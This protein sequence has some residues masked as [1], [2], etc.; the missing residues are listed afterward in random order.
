MATLTKEYINNLLQQSPN[1]VAFNKFECIST[2]TYTDTSDRPYV[3]FKI[4]DDYPDLYFDVHDTTDYINQYYYRDS[5][6][7]WRLNAYLNPC[8]SA[9]AT[10][11]AST[12]Q[13][14]AFLRT[15]VYNWLSIADGGKCGDPNQGVMSVVKYQGFGAFAPP[16]IPTAVIVNNV[17]NT[18]ETHTQNGNAVTITITTQSEYL[19]FATPPNAV[20]TDTDGIQQ[21]TAA[22]V[23][24]VSG[25]VA[26]AWNLSNVDTAV[27]IVLN[28][29]IDRRLWTN[30]L[31]TQ[32][33]V[34]GVNLSNYNYVSYVN[35]ITVNVNSGYHFETSPKLEVYSDSTKLT[36]L[37][38]TVNVN[39]AS[40]TVDLSQY[41]TATQITILGEAVQN[42]F[43]FI[44]NI[45]NST[46]QTSVS[47]NT[48]TATITASASYLKFSTAPTVVYYVN[49]TL[50]TDNMTVATVNDRETA[51]AT[52]TADFDTVQFNGVLTQYFEV[53]YNLTNAT[54]IS[55]KTFVFVT[56]NT[57]QIEVAANNSYCFEVEPTALI[58]GALIYDTLPFTFVGGEEPF[59]CAVITIDLTQYDRNNIQVIEV[60][61]AA[62]PLVA[63]NYGAVNVYKVT[64]A[65]LNAFARLRYDSVHGLVD[66][67][68]YVITLKR[69]Y[70]RIAA[71]V[72]DT[73]KCANYDT[74]INC[75]VPITDTKTI[76]CGTLT[77]PQYA[78]NASDY[79]NTEIT[80][81]MPFVGFYTIPSDYINK[82]ISLVYVV[83][84]VTGKG[85]AKL[86]C[87][88]IVF[89]SY[90]CETSDNMMFEKITNNAQINQLQYNRFEGLQP[91]IIVKHLQDNNNFIANAE[92]KRG[93]ISTFNGYCEFTEIELTAE[94]TATERK[95]IIDA[96]KNGVY[97]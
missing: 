53:E 47:G 93:L 33:T 70:F 56:E 42:T 52:I 77:I 30:A 90:E 13:K 19:G 35:I 16:Q 18:T 72:D 6:S 95:M 31:L 64:K 80:I 37:D 28:G 78:E 76:N 61:A 75:S 94:I 92:C 88:D 62:V 41:P 69:L 8:M 67:G 54:K 2:V 17:A 32:C 39:T 83:S 25:G 24:N 63:Y 87:N 40:L 22:T 50:Q 1:E 79:T 65:N 44:N 36:T 68:N 5:T 12:P 38:F 43:N 29:V 89:A 73:I 60:T 10:V 34:N 23:S 71:T 4:K 96:L 45:G 58:S 85:Y 49:G 74:Q 26:A 11:A 3:Y 55:G 91:Y 66:L 82:E 20:Y 21:T 84:A 46:L 51:T 14:Y 86:S 48:V 15:A 97:V 27:N 59:L 57:L 81:F 9:T 7:E